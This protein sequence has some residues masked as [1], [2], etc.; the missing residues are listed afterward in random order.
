MSA[1][2]DPT[3]IHFPIY[4]EPGDPEWKIKDTR[5]I[6]RAVRPPCSLKL[7]TKEHSGSLSSVLLSWGQLINVTGQL[8]RDKWLGGG[9]KCWDNYPF[10]EVYSQFQLK[11]QEKAGGQMYQQGNRE[12]KVISQCSWGAWRNMGVLERGQAGISGCCLLEHWV[13]FSLP[14]NNDFPSLPFLCFPTL[15]RAQ[16]PRWHVLGW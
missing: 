6:H 3:V 4:W 11:L 13:L 10:W 8:G 15:L 14:G 12:R 5:S 2:R 7:G 16:V 9:G 1:L